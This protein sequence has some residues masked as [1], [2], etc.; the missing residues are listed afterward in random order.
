[1]DVR[2]IGSFDEDQNCSEDEQ[3]NLAKDL[4]VNFDSGALLNQNS[5]DIEVADL[6][7]N[8]LDSFNNPGTVNS[9]TY[10]LQAHI[11]N[12]D[13]IFEPEPEEHAFTNKN[14]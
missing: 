4:G 14:I 2:N 8:D 1:V 10:N 13:S 9:N 12:I 11:K 3:E 7:A 6:V 5:Y